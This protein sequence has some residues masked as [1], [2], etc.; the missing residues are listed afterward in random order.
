V[1]TGDRAARPWGLV[2]VLMLVQVCGTLAHLGPAIV[3]V[4]A[5]PALGVDPAAIGAF[6]AV[7]FLG[8]MLTVLVSGALCA[9]L[10]AVRLSQLGL[11]STAAGCA[12]SAAGSAEAALGG[13]L[14]IGLGYGPVTPASSHLLARHAPA[15]SRALLFSVRQTGLPFGGMLTGLMVPQLLAA[16]G[17]Q[18][19]MLVLGGVCLAMAGGLQPL[20]ATLDADRDPAAPLGLRGMVAGPLRAL[21]TSRAISRLAAISLVFAI[22]QVAFSGYLVVALT[23]MTGMSVAAAGLLLSLAQGG[24]VF[25]RVGWGWLADRTGRPN[26]VLAALALGMAASAAGFA[27]VGPGWPYAALCV[28]ALAIG[29]TSTGW[30]GVYLSELARHA[31]RSAVGQVTGSAL[32]VTYAGSLS[33]P[34]LFGKLIVLFGAFP[35][36]FATLA[37]IGLGTA[38]ATLASGG[39]GRAAR[40]DTA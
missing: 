9:R 14:L 16:L 15:E 30:N 19:A 28:L 39:G 36:A 37:L 35:L 10:G 21:L 32:L 38:A 7:V 40:R 26:A 2:A 34:L 13:A 18:G 27:L 12:L 4:E 5:A 25:G 31:P 22:I 8:A 1:A 3:V 24:G 17:W 29:A 33:G 20:V 6:M 23:A 11:V